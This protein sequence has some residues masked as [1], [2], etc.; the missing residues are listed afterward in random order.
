[1]KE[2]K[3]YQALLDGNC[4]R[5]RK[6]HLF[7]HSLLNIAKLNSTNSSCEKCGLTYESE[8][9]FF[10]GAMYVSYAFSVAI[11]LTVSF[12]V[13]IFFNDPSVSTYIIS[14]ALISLLTYPVNFRYSRIL[15][16]Y[17]FGGIKYDP[18]KIKK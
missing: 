15:F 3:I 8:P 1:M 16:L 10:Y 9:G 2:K 13:T 11:M 17:L 14:V 12:L 6:G 5:C 18:N 4:P 7:T